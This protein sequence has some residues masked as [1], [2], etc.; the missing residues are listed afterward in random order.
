MF[1]NFLTALTVKTLL[2][3]TQAHNKMRDI[4]CYTNKHS[5]ETHTQTAERHTETEKLSPQE[6]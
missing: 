5:F 6:G 2:P 3:L 1:P 4:T